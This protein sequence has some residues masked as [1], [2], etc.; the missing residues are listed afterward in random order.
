MLSLSSKK[1]KKNKRQELR[2]LLY[3]GVNPSKIPN[4][5]DFSETLTLVVGIDSPKFSIDPLNKSHRIVVL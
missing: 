3:S 2:D 4:L 1:R 5:C